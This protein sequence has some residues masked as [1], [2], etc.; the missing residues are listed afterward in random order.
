MSVYQYTNLQELIDLIKREKKAIII[1]FSAKWCSP[2]KT[3]TP[4]YH[5]FATQYQNIIF[6]EVD[7]DDAQDIASAFDVSSMP[8]FKLFKSAK[9]VTEFSGASK[10]KLKQMIMDCK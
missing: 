5:Q 8:T 2:C 3:I 6:I 4:I 9:F 1:K 10:D 7:V